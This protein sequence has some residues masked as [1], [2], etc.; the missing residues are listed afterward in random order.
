[1]LTSGDEL[2]KFPLAAGLVLLFVG[3]ILMSS[4]N[5]SSQRLEVLWDT[6]KIEVNKWEVKADFT[7]GDIIKLEIS[8]GIDWIDYLEPPTSEVPYVNKA[9]YIN[10]TEPSGK[11]S[12]IEVMFIT[13]Y[14]PPQLS[15]FNI[16]V[17]NSNGNFAV[18]E[19]A[20]MGEAMQTGQYTAEVTGVSPR[21]GEPPGS[22]I[23][24]K[25]RINRFTDRPYSAF[26]YP[27]I[28]VFLIGVSLFALSFRKKKYRMLRKKREA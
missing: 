16:T 22:L 17:L 24:Y 4:S 12:Y 10:V 15:I 6:A 3:I 1:M 27:G 7:A 20:I 25:Q 28:A 18:K 5:L 8:P 23:F 13:T 19:R 21:G 11:E 2:R 26:L 14:S 9:V